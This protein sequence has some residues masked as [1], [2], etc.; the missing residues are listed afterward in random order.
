MVR[1]LAHYFIF[2]YHDSHTF[3]LPMVDN[4]VKENIRQE[5]AQIFPTLV[6]LR[7]QIHKNPELGFEEQKTSALVARTLRSLGLR[8]Q[9][10]IA[11]TGVV[12]MLEGRKKSPVV[13]LRADMDALPIH[14]QNKIPYRSSLQG[15]M[16]ACGHDAHT[17]IALGAAMLLSSMK[18]QLDGSVKF[19]FE[20]CEEKSPSGAAELIKRGVLANPKVGAIF[21]MHVFARAEVGRVGFRAGPMMAASDELYITIKGKGGHGAFPHL[22]VDALVVAAE[23]VLAL[24]KVISRQVNP[25]SPHV[26]T[27]G[28]IEG[29]T[30]PNIIP[31]EVKIT[32]TLRSMDEKWRKQARK[33]I[34]RMIKGVTSASGASF[35]LEIKEAGPVLVNDE[36]LTKFA[37]DV[38][39][40]YL[41]P[42]NVFTV[43][44]VMGGEPFAYYLQK[45]PGT[46]FR[47]GIANRRKGI[48]HDLHTPRFNID[49]EALKVGA[50]FFAYLAHEYL[51]SAPRLVRD[52]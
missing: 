32:G 18:D 38:C 22:S 7:R 43:E 27:I 31:N 47:L 1:P 23:V 16:H 6:Q 12:G 25:F 33:S 50:G 19:I 36:R 28:K 20:P 24:Q 10:G 3:S 49:E 39:K 42:R 21:G 48:V 9:A 13:A 51:S 44:P 52:L 37:E 2:L 4:M 29:G 17:A 26:L 30:A 41:G 15:K 34:V 40:D 35:E 14:E 5:T 46:F 45:V 8:V 11:K